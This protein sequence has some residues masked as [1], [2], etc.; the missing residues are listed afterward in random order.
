ML[1]NGWHYMT[2]IRTLQALEAE[3]VLN[4][5]CWTISKTYPDCPIFTIHDSICTTQ[6][7][8]DVASEAMTQVFTDHFDI[9][10]R[11]RQGKM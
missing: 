4:E 6:S 11:I 5:V 2:E 10:P 8:V 9:P 7:Y 3:I 1:R